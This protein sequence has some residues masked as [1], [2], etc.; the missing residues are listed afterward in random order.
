MI[1]EAGSRRTEAEAPGQV[2]RAR[3]L[4]AV[5]GLSLALFAFATVE[6]LPVGLLPQIA[7]GLGVSLPSVGFLVTGYGLVVMATAVPLTA[8]TR[9]IPRRRLLA[10]LMTL[11]TGAT[12]LCGTA[13]GYGVLLGARVLI[14]LTHAV[15]WSVVA[16]AAVGMFPVRVRAKVVATLFGG[17]SLAQVL[18]AP[19]G[20]W[21]GQQTDWRVPFV[22]MS[23]LGL[24]AGI[25][26]VG[27][28]PSTP[29]EEN[30]AAT[31]PAPDRFRFLLLVVVTAVVIGGFFTF[32]TYVTVFLTDV[33]GIS[34]HSV[35]AVFALG[36]AGGVIG[37]SLSGMLSARSTRATMTGSVAAMTAALA[38]LVV[39]GARPAA[40]VAAVTLL[41]PAL[42]GMLTTLTSRILHIV[43]A[44]WTWP[45]RRVPPPSR[46]AS[47]PAPSSAGAPWTPT[48]RTASPFSACA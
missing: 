14:A 26:V 47:P 24:I 43:P 2:P 9:R 15:M 11:F 6:A 37:T 8:V 20:T 30:P 27:M 19:A 25:V 42:S 48:A 45:P 44:T 40:S 33:A 29:V 12:L 1:T 31:A 21:L 7:H 17:S 46:R 5:A 3:A 10:V 13:P 16:S 28:L 4:V 32:Y 41:L 38:L 34:S 39:A 35:G 36:G 18:G 23:A 22:V